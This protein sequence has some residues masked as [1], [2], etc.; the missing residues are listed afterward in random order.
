MASSRC[1]RRCS[2]FSLAPLSPRSPASAFGI[3]FVLTVVTAVDLGPC[4]T[5]VLVVFDPEGDIV[6]DIW[7][8]A[9]AEPKPSTKTDAMIIFTFHSFKFQQSNSQLSQPENWI[10]PLLTKCPLNFGYTAQK[11]NT[12][13]MLCLFLVQKADGVPAA[14]SKP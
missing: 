1:A 9:G 13:R 6:F 2:I 4:V 7:A 5:I 11:M 3:T 14:H 8:K 12:R 10:C